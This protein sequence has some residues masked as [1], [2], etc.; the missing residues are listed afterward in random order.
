MLFRVTIQCLMIAGAVKALN[1]DISDQKA[2]IHA[3]KT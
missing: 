3:L 2:L 1:G